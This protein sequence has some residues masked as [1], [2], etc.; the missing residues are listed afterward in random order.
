MAPVRLTLFSQATPIATRLRSAE[1][2]AVKKSSCA[3]ATPFS[4]LIFKLASAELAEVDKKSP[5]QITAHGAISLENEVS[6]RKG[7]LDYSTG[8]GTIYNQK[9]QPFRFGRAALISRL[10]LLWGRCSVSM[11]V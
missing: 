6:T 11:N 3:Y 4:D 2:A 1:T 10:S 5:H 7:N 8:G 9:E